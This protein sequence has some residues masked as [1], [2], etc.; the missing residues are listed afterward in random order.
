[1]SEHA[2]PSAPD[3]RPILAPPSASPAEASRPDIVFDEHYHAYES[4]PV[5]WWLTLI[6]LSFLVGGA[7]Y[8]I[9]NMLH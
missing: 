6:W 8:L 1:M 2:P 9:V 3:T 4:N 5:P 7:L